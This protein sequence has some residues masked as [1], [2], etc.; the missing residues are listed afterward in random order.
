MNK[1][2][3]ALEKEQYEQIIETIRKGFTHDGSELKPNK[4][5][6]TALV[7]QANLGV[8]ISDILKLTISDIV[9][10]SGRYRLDIV[11]QKTGKSR[12]FTVP[13]ALYDFLVEYASE[14]RIG[15]KARLFPVCER[16]I[17]KQL[18]IVAD[19]LGIEGVSTHS[20]R[21][22]YATQIYQ[23]NDYDIELVRHLLQHSSASV[24]QR[25]I[26]ISSKRVETAINNHLCLL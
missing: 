23:N 10:D 2:T 9:K 15:Q 4:R 19:Y 11:E 6:A 12:D 16:A 18:K 8:R 13:N 26:G 24:T 25:Y 7:V 20:F 21:K 14:N 22:F 5:L 17:Q 3:K 1:R